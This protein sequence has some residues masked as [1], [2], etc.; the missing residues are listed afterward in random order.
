[1]VSENITEIGGDLPPMSK[2]DDE[3]IAC[4][5]DQWCRE[6]MAELEAKWRGKGKTFSWFRKEPDYASGY[7]SWF[8]LDDPTEPCARV[9]RFSMIGGGQIKTS[10]KW[11]WRQWPDGRTK[12]DTWGTWKDDNT[13][14]CRVDRYP[15]V[16]VVAHA[17]TGVQR[18]RGGIDGHL[19]DCPASAAVF[20]R[21]V[22]QEIVDRVAATPA[23]TTVDEDTFYA[24][25]DFSEGCAFCRRP[26]R[27]EISKLVAV[28]P[29]CARKHG[30]PH[31]MA[32]ASKRLESTSQGAWRDRSMPSTEGRDAMREPTRRLRC[33]E[34]R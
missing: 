28:G 16:T 13:V 15:T 12:H 29:D 1:M 17:S 25:L 22:P 11:D 10:Q 34:I 2:E 24:L 33:G 21:R 31:S 4:Q 19:S 20:D 14:L 32:A 27:D 8:F 9:F 26:L 7:L 18:Y 23:A 6:G 5:I 30:V 3:K